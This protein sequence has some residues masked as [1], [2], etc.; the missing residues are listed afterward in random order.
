M[1]Y[2]LLSFLLGQSFQL[3][4]VIS[5]WKQEELNEECFFFFFIFFIFFIFFF[6][7]LL[8]LCTCVLAYIGAS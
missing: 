5:G 3:Y 7:L 4:V 6:L 1:L 2:I 8:H